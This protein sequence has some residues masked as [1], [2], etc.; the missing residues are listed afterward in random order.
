MKLPDRAGTV[1]DLRATSKTKSNYGTHLQS[2]FQ[3]RPPEPFF[4]SLR[5]ADVAVVSAGW[6]IRQ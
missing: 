5:T 2:D 4:T 1:Q 3:R 6:K